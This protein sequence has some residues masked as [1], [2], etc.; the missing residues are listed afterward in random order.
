MIDGA[1]TTY[2]VAQFNGPAKRKAPTF[3]YHRVSRTRSA[4]AATATDPVDIDEPAAQPLTTSFSK[5]RKVMKTLTEYWQDYVTVD[6]VNRLQVLQAKVA[7][8][9]A[10]GKKLDY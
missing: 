9:K 8:A 10:P 3:V 7:D 6:D 1:T 2:A 5:F 4:G